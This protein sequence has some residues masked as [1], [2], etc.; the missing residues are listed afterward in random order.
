MVI[1][2]AGL[3]GASAAEELRERGFEGAIRLFG[4][5]HSVPYLRPPLSKGYL[6][7]TEGWDAVELHPREWYAEHGIELITGTN[8]AAID[9]SAHELVLDDGARERYDRLLLATGSE[10]VRPELPG[11]GL[12]GVHVLRTI[13]QSDELKALLHGGEKSIVVIGGGWIGM[14]LAATARTLGHAVT[15]VE[16]GRVPLASALGERLGGVFLALHEEH[17]V[18]FRHEATVEA[19]EGDA[20]VTGVRLASGEVLRAELVV[21]AVGARPRIELAA[22]AGLETADGVLVDERLVTSDPDILAAGDIASHLHPDLHG[23]RVRSEH[24]ANAMNGGRAAARAMLGDERPYDDIPYFYTDQFELGMEYSGFAPLTG[25]ARVVI[26]GDL[27]AREF[28]A[29]WVLGARVVAGMNVNVWDVNDEVQRLIRS[30]A[31]LDDA[32]LADPAIPLAE[33]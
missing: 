31:E 2:G 18:A 20:A 16:R 5:E 12:P 19:I 8:A 25:T 10:P 28:I 6:A 27:A 30:R 21:L 1:V 24:W 15:V 9:R 14:E 7:G 3:A 29:F 22:A 13:E 11:V 17:G 23:I 33:L 26:R 32:R 4:S